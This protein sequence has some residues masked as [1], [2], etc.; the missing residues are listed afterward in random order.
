[1][2]TKA[3]EL[4]AFD[5]RHI[6]HPYTSATTP[7]TTYLVESAQGVRIQLAGGESLID[8]MASWWCAIHGY[9]NPILNQAAKDQID[10]VSH[11]MFGG[12]THRPATELCKLLID[13]SAPN[14]NHVFLADSGSIS[15]EVAMKM[16]IQYWQA[17]GKGNKNKILSP[18]GGY[19]G[20]T[21][22]AMSVCDPSTGMHHLFSDAVTQQVFTDRPSC[23]FGSKFSPSSTT[24]L[25]NQIKENKDVLAAIILEPV[26]QGAGGMWFYHPDY[27]TRVRELCDEHDILLIADE[28]ATG[29]GRTG[30]LF[31]CEWASIEPDIL[32]IGKALTGGYMSLAATLATSKVATGISKNGGVFMHGPTFMGNPLACAVALASLRLLLESDWE[33]KIQNIQQQMSSTLEPATR[34]NSVKDVR[35]LGA[36]GVLEMND[37]VNVETAQA[38]FKDEGVWIRPFGHLVYIMPPYIINESDLNTLCKSMLSFANSLC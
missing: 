16:A 7:L 37:T 25:E 9:N 30:K 36:I 27:L 32:C 12:L 24:D 28:I 29:F 5:R 23:V 1:M 17:Q 19:H 10:S 4:L 21:F 33:L 18:R 13:I 8:G 2:N 34:I 3:D 6:W 14:L 26:V 31:A 11:V 22:A 38:F 35:V 20:D 15:V